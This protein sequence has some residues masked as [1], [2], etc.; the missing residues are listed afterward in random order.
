VFR[1]LRDITDQVVFIHMDPLASHI[2]PALAKVFPE[3]MITMP[4]QEVM[5]GL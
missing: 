5:A 4:L 2:G 3:D 1:E